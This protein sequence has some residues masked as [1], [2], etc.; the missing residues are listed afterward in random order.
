MRTLS[1]LIWGNNSRSPLM[2]K[3][4]SALVDGPILVVG[5]GTVG[6][7]MEHLKGDIIAFDV[8]P[9]DVTSFVADGHNIPIATG[10]VGGV[11]IQAVL[12]H[13][14]DPWQV[15]AE[16]HRVLKPG[17][18]VY[19]DTPFM[20]PVHEGAYDF[21]RFSRNGHRWL[22]R[23]FEE[24]EAGASVGVGWAAL[25]SLRH[26]FITLF[27]NRRIGSLVASLFLWLR[28]IDKIRPDSYAGAG[29]FYFL[30]RK[31][32]T[33]LHPRDMVAYYRQ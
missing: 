33:E 18:V 20:Q 30:G 32:D 10:S 15:V 1:P 14:I 23:R 8:Y 9:T 31:S 3:K 4:F 11:W 13:V 2:A 29:G 12:E 25:L 26:A 28:L 21:T 17:G 7:G 22:F 24:I 27:R 6:N 16:I 5:G 19:A